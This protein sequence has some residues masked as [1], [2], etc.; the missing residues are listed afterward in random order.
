MTH[1]AIRS[2]RP[3]WG[4]G[5]LLAMV[6][7]SAVLP[8]VLPA[9]IAS[10]QDQGAAASTP[11]GLLETR[12]PARIADDAVRLDLTDDLGSW[13]ADAFPGETH[14]ELDALDAALAAQGSTRAEVRMV[15]A[16]AGEDG[17]V[18][19]TGFQL[20]DGD[21]QALRDAILA[22]YF[23]GFG[24]LTRTDQ[25]VAGRPVTY[26]SQGPLGSDPYP[27]GVLADGDGLWVVSA[28]ADLL[29]PAMEALVGAATGALPRLDPDATGDGYVAPWGWEGTMR[30]TVTWNQ[31]SYRGTATATFT[32]AWLQPLTTVR[33]CDDRDCTSYIPTGSIDWS[34]DVSA[35]TRPRCSAS[36]RGSLAP[37]G[38][39]FP[40]DQML[41]LDPTDDDHVRFW[42]SGTFHVPDQP[43]V[44]WEGDRGPGSFFSIPWPEDPDPFADE[45]SDQYPS[46]ANRQ[47]RISSGD[48]RITGRCWNY[49]E[50]GY[51][52]V[53][54]WDLVATDE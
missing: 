14:P 2:R 31:A 12:L 44:G 1:G 17:D 23:L 53:V 39:V 28:E 38:V 42:G 50:S 29:G 7:A 25:D 15:W 30:Q 22:V 11:D 47:W 37:G 52:D 16:S 10:A 41:F 35:P 26:L 32:G 20:P 18:Q 49:H 51:E 4:R 40:T 46:C 34:W 6:L 48:T 45:S 33:Y 24:E 43:C 3:A 9:P 13:L 8:G 5:P 27:F 36:T 54:E 19:F 21:A